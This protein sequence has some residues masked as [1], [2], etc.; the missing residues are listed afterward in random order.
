MRVFR[1]IMLGGGI[2]IASLPET[3]KLYYKATAKVSPVNGSLG[4]P[5]IK[6]SWDSTTGEGVIVCSKDISR[7]DK[8]AFRS[9]TSLTSITIPDGVTEL[10]LY[11]FE[12]CTNLTN[13]TIPDSVMV[14]ADGIFSGCTSLPTI[15]DIRYADTYLIKVLDNTHTEYTIKN[16]TRFIGV[17][18]FENCSSLTSITIP[19]S[20]IYIGGRAF[21]GCRGHLIINSPFVE[22]D[23]V[24]NNTFLTGT[25]FS[26]ITS[27]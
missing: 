26:K 25:K 19:D 3:R 22:Y 15:D 4:S 10:G 21:Y 5:I 13:I 27:I 12:N 24:Y 23:Y 17:N 16:D 9:N 1:R 11:A 2:D 18:A 20:V 14:I 7:I 8:S 6:N